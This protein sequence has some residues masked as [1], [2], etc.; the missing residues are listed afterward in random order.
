MTGV[1]DRG[2][3]LPRSPACSPPDQVTSKRTWLKPNDW[4]SILTWNKPQKHTSVGRLTASNVW[5]LGVRRIHTL[6]WEV[7]ILVSSRNWNIP[8]ITWSIIPIVQESKGH[9][10]NIFWANP[11]Q[12]RKKVASPADQASDERSRKLVFILQSLFLERTPRVASSV[13]K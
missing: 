4:T 2:G 9:A 13:L 10:K 11:K 6:A 8:R 12:N 3:K 5:S 1:I 7:G